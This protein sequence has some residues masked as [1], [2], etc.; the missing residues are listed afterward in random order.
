[1]EVWMII[2]IM[3]I[4]AFICSISTFFMYLCCKKH[5]GVE[6]GLK[7][8]YKC[9]KEDDNDERCYGSVCEEGKCTSTGVGD[10]NPGFS[11]GGCE[12][13]GCSVEGN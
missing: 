8:K 4:P 9:S 3:L 13:G 5:G 7:Y 10:N 12:S 11:E 2:I 6:T 1:M